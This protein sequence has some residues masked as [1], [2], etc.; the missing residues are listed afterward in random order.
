MES[1]GDAYSERALPGRDPRRVVAGAA[2]FAAG[3]LAVVVGMLLVTTPLS[4][5]AGASGEQAAQRLAGLLA[6]LGIPAALLG[7]VAVLPARRHE[8]AGAVVGAAVCVLGVA[9]FWHAYPVRWTGSGQSL[10][11][12]TSMVYFL[13]GCIAFWFV[14][15][16]I[17][18]Y[19]TRNNPYGTVELELTRQGRTRTVEVSRREYQQ[20]RRAIRGDGGENEQVIRELESRFED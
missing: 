15:T 17:A 16:A 1:L 5:L 3:A 8:R 13:G 10:A 20:Y 19:R 12:E 18:D 6:G 4:A 14:L 9:L 11:F 2:L 7:V